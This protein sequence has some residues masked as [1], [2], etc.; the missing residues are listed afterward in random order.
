VLNEHRR[1]PG[2]AP[3]GD[4]LPSVGYQF[5]L[6]SPE[7]GKPT[8]AMPI[9]I[10][11]LS[12]TLRKIGSQPRHGTVS[13]ALWPPR[14]AQIYWNCCGVEFILPYPTETR[15]NSGSTGRVE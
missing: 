6:K 1:N 8:A 9:F 5:N 10:P 12:P 3:F 15:Q 14:T 13:L 11:V 2:I 7:L 4:L